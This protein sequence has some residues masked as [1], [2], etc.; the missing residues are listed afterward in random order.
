MSRADILAGLE[1]FGFDEIRVA[2]EEPEWPHG[3]CFA[4]AALRNRK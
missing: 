4:L 3:P 2:F 1:H